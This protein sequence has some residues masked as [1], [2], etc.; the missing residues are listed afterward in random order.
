MDKNNSNINSE[1]EFFGK[2]LGGIIIVIAFFIL[3]ACVTEAAKPDD[4]DLEN[5]AKYN[6]CSKRSSTYYKCNWSTWENRCVCKQR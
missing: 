4:K 2:I 5:I 3:K 6:S 1:N